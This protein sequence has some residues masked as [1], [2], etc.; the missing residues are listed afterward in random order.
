MNCKLCGHSKAAHP[1]L[2]RCKQ[3]TRI[4]YEGMKDPQMQL[5]TCTEFMAR[6]QVRY[7]VKFDW[8]LDRRMREYLGMLGSKG[9][10]VPGLVQLFREAMEEYLKRRGY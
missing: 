1:N 6:F 3:A 4:K 7:V 5:C 10:R 8:M 9:E 2:G